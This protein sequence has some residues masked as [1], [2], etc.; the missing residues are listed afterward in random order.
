ML[1]AGI[2][3]N[4]IASNLLTICRKKYRD[5]ICKASVNFIINLLSDYQLFISVIKFTGRDPYHIY[6]LHKSGIFDGKF[7]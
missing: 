7:L 6:T 4:S 2:F 3:D 5:L 1:I